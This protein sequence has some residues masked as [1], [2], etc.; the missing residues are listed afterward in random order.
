MEL[1]FFLRQSVGI[2][3]LVIQPAQRISISREEKRQLIAIR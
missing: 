2:E 3:K 1:P